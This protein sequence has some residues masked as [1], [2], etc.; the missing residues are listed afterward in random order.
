MAKYQSNHNPATIDQP[1]SSMPNLHRNASNH[2]ALGRA[3]Q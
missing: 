1:D 2:S 3:G